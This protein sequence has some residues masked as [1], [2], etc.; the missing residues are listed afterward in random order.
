M[1]EA[2]FLTIGVTLG[3]TLCRLSMKESV[4]SLTLTIEMLQ[5]AFNARFGVRTPVTHTKPETPVTS[6]LKDSIITD[7]KDLPKKAQY[8]L[9][10]PDLKSIRNAAI[11][12]QERREKMEQ[13]AGRMI[14]DHL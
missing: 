1:T 13:N 10:P 6:P 4:R 7:E 3:Y 5:G 11:Q 14:G 12:A 8:D 9:K 2:I